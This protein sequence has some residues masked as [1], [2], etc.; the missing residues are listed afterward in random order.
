MLPVEAGLVLRGQDVCNNNKMASDDLKKDGYLNVDVAAR[1]IVY[2][3]HL[4]VILIFTK[5]GDVKVLDVNSGVILQSCHLS[6][7]NSP[8]NGKYIA[9]QDKILV[10]DAKSF[11]YRGDYNGVLLLDT[12]LQ[13]PI[14]CPDQIVSLELLLSEAILFLQTLRNLVDCGVSVCSDVIELL[15]ERI[16]E[17]QANAKKGIKAQKVNINI[18]IKCA[19]PF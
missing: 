7:P 14:G 2:H 3:P 10:W 4:N 19:F 6:D 9:K 13:R 12:I 1:N 16:Q 11:G 18:I 5:Y 8:L 17:A 15:T